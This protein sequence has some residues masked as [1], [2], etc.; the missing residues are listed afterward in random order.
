MLPMEEAIGDGWFQ[1]VTITSKHNSFDH[2]ASPS[3]LQN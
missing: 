2:Y 3:M 1:P